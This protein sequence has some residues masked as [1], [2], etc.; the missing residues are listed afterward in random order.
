[1]GPLEARIEMKM[2]VHQVLKWVALFVRGLPSWLP[3]EADMRE[4]WAR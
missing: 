2:P 4:A 1:M 3:Q